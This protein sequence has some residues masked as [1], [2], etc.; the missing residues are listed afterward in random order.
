MA[1]QTVRVRE[2]R[3]TKDYEFIKSGTNPMSG[4]V[5]ILPSG[6]FVKPI[7]EIYVPKEAKE[8]NIWTHNTKRNIYV[9]CRFGIISIPA[10]IVE[11]LP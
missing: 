8:R 10:S 2:Y 4:N 6:S 7:D 3:T 1:F 5:L 9:F 11:E